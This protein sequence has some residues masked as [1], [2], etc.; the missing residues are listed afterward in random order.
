MDVIGTGATVAAYFVKKEQRRKIL[1]ITLITG[2]S[3]IALMWL[4]FGRKR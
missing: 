3:L 2:V 1:R 4:L